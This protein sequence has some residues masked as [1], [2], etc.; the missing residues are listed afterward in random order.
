MNRIACAIVACLIV[1]L[2]LSAQEACA[3]IDT[4]L[5]NKQIQDLRVENAQ[6]KM[7]IDSLKKQITAL[8]AQLEAKQSGNDAQ[9]EDVDTPSQAMGVKT[10]VVI[11]SI[12]KR[13]PDPEPQKKLDEARRTHA[14]LQARVDSTKRELDKKET[15]NTA[16]YNWWLDHDSVWR[17]R[18]PFQKPHGDESLGRSRMAWTDATKKFKEN[19]ALIKTLERTSQQELYTIEATAA[20]IP[21]SSPP[22]TEPMGYRIHCQAIH[23]ERVKKWKAGDRIAVVGNTISAESNFTV[24]EARSLEDAP[25]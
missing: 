9:V 3:Q 21:P 20:T 10:I 15:E 1:I 13:A 23:A 8:Q 5:L 19:E 17:A 2:G 14:A 4:A 25:A 16:R 12:N 18:N 7:T 11:R 22:G 24:I 6:L